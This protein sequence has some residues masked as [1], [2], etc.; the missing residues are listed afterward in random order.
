MG[1]SGSKKLW[2]GGGMRSCDLFRHKFS[3]LDIKTSQIIPGHRMAHHPAAMIS[4]F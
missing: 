4:A 1:S 3:N 2:C